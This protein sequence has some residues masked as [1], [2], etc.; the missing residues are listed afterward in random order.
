MTAPA[1]HGDTP[2][3]T[4]RV[5]HGPTLRWAA[6]N[7]RSQTPEMST[8]DADMYER[9]AEFFDRLATDVDRLSA[10]S[11]ATPVCCCEGYPPEIGGAQHR[12]ECPVHGWSAATPDAAAQAL[13]KLVGTH[14]PNGPVA[15]P[16]HLHHPPVYWRIKCDGND[17]S[18]YAERP[19]YWDATAAHSDHLT[20]VLLANGWTNLDPGPRDQADQGTRHRDQPGRCGDPT[21]GE[22]HP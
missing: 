18:F 11:A 2:D 8:R 12:D 21:C 5:P 10:R 6:T 3:L 22:A 19:R 9:I 7:L 13:R 17:C 15:E 16:D 14:E 20:E 4:E 1:E